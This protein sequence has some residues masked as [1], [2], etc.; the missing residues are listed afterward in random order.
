MQRAA[1][2]VLG[3][4]DVATEKEV[5]DEIKYHERRKWLRPGKDKSARQSVLIGQEKLIDYHRCISELKGLA[6]EKNLDEESCGSITD[7]EGLMY[8]DMTPNGN[9]CHILMDCLWTSKSQVLKRRG[10]TRRNSH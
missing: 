1:M 3:L 8:Q 6:C 9:R 5:D 2:T 4:T 10:R 7:E